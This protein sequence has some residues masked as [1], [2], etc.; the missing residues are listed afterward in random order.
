M[1]LNGAWRLG[2]EC[3][4]VSRGEVKGGRIGEMA[5]FGMLALVGFLGSGTKCKSMLPLDCVISET[6]H[7]SLPEYSKVWRRDCCLPLGDGAEEI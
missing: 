6:I 2:F 1:E 5:G 4:E 7:A 3:V